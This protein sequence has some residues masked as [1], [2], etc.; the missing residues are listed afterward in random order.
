MSKECEL[1]NEEMI[2]L[3]LEDKLDQAFRKEILN[4]VAADN[5]LAMMYAMSRILYTG[6]H[7]GERGREWQGVAIKEQVN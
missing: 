1:R 5:D 6:H 7:C 3:L 2:A 4:R